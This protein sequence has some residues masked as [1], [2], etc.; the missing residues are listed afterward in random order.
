MQQIGRYRIVGELGRGAMG[1]VYRAQDPAI[2]RTVAI[3]T[4]RLNDLA[5]TA[6]REKL[7]ERLYREAQ[8][9]GVLSHPGIVTIYDV[10][11]ENEVA[12]IAMEFVDGPTLDKMLVTEPPDANLVLS[13]V[14]QTAAALDY[15]HKRGIIHRDIKPANIMV[16]E[17]SVAKITDFGVAKVESHQL[18]HA[19]GLVGTPNYMSPEQ[20]QGL[21]VGGKS[22]QFSLAV[23]A[24]E[25]FTGEKP[26]V[27]D[28]I[29]ALVFKIVREDPP[30]VG[31]L[32]PSLGWAVDTVMKRALLK[33]PDGRY[34]TCSD[35][36]F[37]LENACRTSKG[38]RP[39]APGAMPDLPT[40]VPPSRT[41][42]RPVPAPVM[43]PVMG[44]PEDETAPIGPVP[45]KG[46]PPPPAE[47]EHLEPAP[48]DPPFVLRLAR[49]L[50]IITLVAGVLSV[51]VVGGIEYLSGGRDETAALA[52]QN[53]PVRPRP[54]RRARASF[55]P[56]EAPT[57]PALPSPTQAPPRPQTTLPADPDRS[58]AQ[59]PT[60]PAEI[61]LI[62]NPPG[63]LLII[64]GNSASSCTSPC[65]LTLAPGRHTIAAT[66]E[67][68]RRTLRIFETPR[69][70]EIFLNLDRT[71]GTLLVSSD[72]PGATIVING[73]ERPEKTPAM[74]NLPTGT[75][76]I[77]VEK[78]GRRE[79]RQVQ[80]RDSVSA[81]L[82]FRIEQ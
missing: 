71:T 28:S 11:E 64:D 24:Y 63:A 19:G 79:G 32:N 35:F 49:V 54:E 16:H 81:S 30:P 72:P 6:E 34:P 8:S 18:T 73:K 68:F 47:T 20:I 9:A 31:Q 80:V 21:E 57:E 58:T 77:E 55:P 36:A 25:L 13:I 17:R 12:Y 2:G 67:G 61:R 3:K 52:D 45:F 4:I 1:I 50:A 76:S 56:Q 38:W 26:F 7:R 40:L 75:H 10:S 15:A 60:G 62:T 46:A 44:D 37:A 65:S 70:D 42:A 59:E 74:L 22:D 48:T 43:A 27:G 78:D 39:I 5:D 69:E 82:V 66:R 51:I 53:Q 33:D 29:P 41:M 23:I 14:T